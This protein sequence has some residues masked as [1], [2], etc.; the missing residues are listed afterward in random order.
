MVPTITHT[1]ASI[2]PNTGVAWDFTNPVTYTVT[3]AD[4]STQTYTVTVTVAANPAK[5][6]TAFNFNGLNLPVTGTVNEASK[7]I[8]LT[9]PYGT[10][11]TAL[12]PTITHTGASI[13]PNTG[14]AQNFTSPVEYTVTAADSSTQK[15]T[16]TVTVAVIEYTITYTAGTGGTITGAATQTVNSGA[17]GEAVTAIP[18]SGYDFVGWSDGVTTATRTDSNVTGNITVTANFAR[19]TSTLPSDTSVTIPTPGVEILIN[20]DKVDYTISDINVENSKKITTIILDDEKLTIKLNKENH[21]STVTIPISNNSDIVIGQLSG[22]TVKNMEVRNAI[23]EIKTEYVTYTIPTVDINIDSILKSLGSQV[24]L[25]DIKVQISVSKSSKETITKVEESAST[26]NFKI[27]VNPVDF[28]ITCTSQGKT[29]EVSKFNGYVERSVAIPDGIDPTKITTGVI[30]NED[31]TFSHVPTAVKL[32][33]GKYYAKINSLTNSTY[34]LIWNPVTFQDV[35]KHWSKDYVN[36][37]GSRMIDDGVGNSSF[38]PNRAITRAEFASMIVK[39]LGLK[40]TNFQ[41]KFK[42]VKESDPNYYDIYTAY[43][44]G[45][46]EGYSNGTFGPQDLI[47]REQAMTMLVKAM[48]IAGMDVKVSKSDVKEQLNRF[49]DSSKISLGARLT[50]TICLKNDIFVGDKKGSLNPKGNLTR[51]ESA[52]VIIRV[53]KKAGL[54]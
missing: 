10:D 24:Q 21:G 45:I 15:Y 46:I 37:V 8:A 44:Y 39:A 51:G 5:E 42:D 53:L 13:S 9:V 19:N 23:L 16:V 54:I 27:V 50:A 30:L 38:A 31:G 48:D 34:T 35:E 36:S 49:K 32:V 6:I 17:D 33:D 2:S 47:T 43:E 52:T 41:E 40:G 1:G 26:Y 14:V 7:T 25:K 28:E 11:I 29:V 20:N 12:V 18:N 4:S 22:Q 3:A